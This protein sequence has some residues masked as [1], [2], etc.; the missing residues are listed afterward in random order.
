MRH[1]ILLFVLL[2]ADRTGL[3]QIGGSTGSSAF[4]LVSSARVASLGGNLIAVKDNDPS[5]GIHNPALLNKSMDRYLSMSYVNYFGNINY[6]FLSYVHDVDTLA[7]FS[8]TLNYLSYGR[9]KETDE[10]GQ[11]LGEFSAGDYVLNLGTGRRIDSLFSVG[12]NFKTLYSSYYFVNGLSFALDGGATYHR[13]D[14]GFTASFLV[15]NV[16]VNVKPI[17][18]GN[19]E[20][21]PFDIQF[22]ISQKLKHAPFR[23]S[24]AAE[25]LHRWDLSYLDPTLKPTIDPS[26]GEKIEPKAPGFG[27]K[28][29]RHAIFGT[30]LVTKNFFIGFGFNYRRRAE[31]RV[32]ERSGLSG[33]SFGMGMKIK[34]FHLSYALA[35]YNQ[36][37]LSNHITIAFNL[38]EFR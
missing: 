18:P 14:K 28:L 38:N 9:F 22:G 35:T 21:L 36:A 32:R 19:R 24:V 11:E 23:F 3:A 26:T 37:G 16:G 25:N 20:K 15:R 6:G 7:T 4:N 8:A 29:M 10:T 13:A 27:D 30:E 33:F 12:L 31:L 1:L 2:F 17:N 5:L 34:K